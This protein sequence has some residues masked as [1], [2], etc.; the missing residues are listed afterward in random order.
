MKKKI[1]AFL[2]IFSA[3]TAFAQEGSSDLRKFRFGVRFAPSIDWIKPAQNIKTMS[4]EKMGFGLSYGIM[5]ERNFNNSYSFV[6][7][8]NFTQLA[9]SMTFVEDTVT[10]TTTVG[11][12]DL[13]YLSET[14]NSIYKY[15]MSYIEVPLLLKMRTKEIGYFTYFMELGGNVA[16]KGKL[17]V[18]PA[19]TADIDFDN[20]KFTSQVDQELVD[21]SDRFN[22]FRI[23]GHVGAGAEYNLSGNTSAIASISFHPGFTNLY[24]TKKSKTPKTIVFERDENGDLQWDDDDNIKY[25]EGDVME[26]NI[27]YVALNIGLFF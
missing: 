5:V 21:L 4:R 6:T 11:G 26:A 25:K 23:S 2:C 24:R 14:E 12:N 18:N 7:G 8:V 27:S 19:V 9:S 3:I 17:G 10:V 15:K 1:A 13:V 16:I 20:A 22:L